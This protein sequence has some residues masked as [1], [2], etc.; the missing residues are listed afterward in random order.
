MGLTPSQATSVPTDKFKLITQ[1]SDYFPE[2]MLLRNIQNG[3]ISRYSGGQ[4]HLVSVPVATK[5]GLT[6]NDVVTITADQYGKVSKGND[7]FPEGML[8]QNVQTSEVDLY[9]GG[10]RH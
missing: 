6:A 2:G 8:I 4:F 10:Q 9:S 3:E 1:G 5:M 7:Y